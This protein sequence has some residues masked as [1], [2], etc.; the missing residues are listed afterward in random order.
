MDEVFREVRRAADPA[1]LTESER[2]HVPVLESPAEVT[3]G[4]MFPVT[5]KVGQ[6]PHPLDAGHF[7]Q[8]IDLYADQ[9]LVVRVMFTPTAPMPKFTCYLVLTESATLRAVAFCDLHGFWE[10]TQWVRAG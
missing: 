4:E 5:V 7:C 10:S 2:K 9:T 8:S 3:P 1:R 6:E